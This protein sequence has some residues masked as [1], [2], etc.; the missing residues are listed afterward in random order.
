MFIGDLAFFFSDD[1][2][3]LITIH[4]GCRLSHYSDENFLI[5]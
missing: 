3:S 1:S 2:T 5:K 4:K